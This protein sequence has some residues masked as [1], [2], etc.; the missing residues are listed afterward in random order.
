MQVL[1]TGVIW[2]TRDKRGFAEV[3]R[4]EGFVPERVSTHA[5]EYIWQTY[6][7]VTDAI[8]MVYQHNGH[9][10]YVLTFP[11]A[12]NGYGAT[13]VYDTT[14]KLWHQRGWWDSAN[15]T[16]H[17][18]RMNCVCVM[19]S[20]VLV[21]DYLNGNIY[22]LSDG[23]YTE[24]GGTPLVSVRRAPHLQADHMQQYFEMLQI[25]FQPGVGNSASPNPQAMLKWSDDGGSTWSSE[26][27]TS[28]GPQG[29][30]QNRAIWFAMGTARDRVFEVR[31]SD[32]VNRTIVNATLLASV[33]AH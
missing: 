2:L 32:P 33:G 25:E 11:S 12:N 23:V 13:W 7:T 16:F 20:Q 24:A 4:T 8:A 19:G 14:T 6:V 30:Y 17:R 22:A 29:S 18:A 21:G 1:K 3:W 10:F 28:I 5:M 26:H 9:E 15:S 27:W 31:V